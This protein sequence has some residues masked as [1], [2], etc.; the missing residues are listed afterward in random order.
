MTKVQIPPSAMEEQI[1]GLVRWVRATGG[2][3]I[4]NG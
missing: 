3:V 2:K 1:A 4:Y